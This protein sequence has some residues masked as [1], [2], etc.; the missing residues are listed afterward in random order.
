MLVKNNY[1][2]LRFIH[3]IITQHGGII[4]IIV[5]RWLESSAM[6]VPHIVCMLQKGLVILGIMLVGVLVLFV[7][8]ALGERTSSTRAHQSHLGLPARLGEVNLFEF[9]PRVREL[10]RNEQVE[11][12]Q[13]KRVN[14]VLDS[15]VRI[16]SEMRRLLTLRGQDKWQANQAYGKAIRVQLKLKQIKLV[17]I[18]DENVQCRV[19]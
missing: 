7:L 10:D 8:G 15:N 18:N 3:D 11:K 1:L 4:C 9:L 19:D 6:L 12:H 13:A 5:P 17:Q 14:Q 2:L 16:E